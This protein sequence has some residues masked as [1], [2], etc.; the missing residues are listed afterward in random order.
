MAKVISVEQRRRILAHIASAKAK[1]ITV[2][3]S[4]R[5]HGIAEATYYRWC[6]MYDVESADFKQQVKLLASENARLKELVADL[7]L[8]TR[9]LKDVVKKKW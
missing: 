2:V 3:Q 9:M 5:K 4:C 8:Q 7:T 6:S 1:G